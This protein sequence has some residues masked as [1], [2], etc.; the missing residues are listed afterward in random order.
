MFISSLQGAKAYSQTGWGAMAGF[1]PL[2]NYTDWGHVPGTQAA[3]KV[4]AYFYW[5]HYS[6]IADPEVQPFTRHNMGEQT[7]GGME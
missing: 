4:Y 1:V 5:D 7:V 6:V 3:P 2:D